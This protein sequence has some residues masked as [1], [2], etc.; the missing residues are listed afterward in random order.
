MAKAGAW[1][2]P[3]LAAQA[4][5]RLSAHLWELS[6]DHPAAD[7]NEYKMQ[8][9]VVKLCH[10]WGISYWPLVTLGEGAR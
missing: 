9:S 8:R 5:R 3:S 6:L 10:K 7:H 4:M 1:Y 2:Q